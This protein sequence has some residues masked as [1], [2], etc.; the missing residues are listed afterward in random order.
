[1]GYSVLQVSYGYQP[2]NENDP[3][4]RVADDATSQ[5]GM[6]LAPGG[7]VVDALPFCKYTHDLRMES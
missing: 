7:F 1:M 5:L 4:V 6:L 2:Q 3:L